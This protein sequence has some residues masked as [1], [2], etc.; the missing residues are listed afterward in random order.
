VKTKR[1]V[2]HFDDLVDGREGAVVVQVGGSGGVQ[3][4]V[5]LGDDDD[6]FF[7]AERLD[8]LD[9]AFAPDGEGE[10]GVGKENSIADWEHGDDAARLR[11]AF[12][13]A[14]AGV[15]HAEEVAGHE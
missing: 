7:V 2:G 11:G 13:I 9:G 4:G 10:N 12:G 3:V 15:N 1:L 8:E 5:A 14:L 6:G